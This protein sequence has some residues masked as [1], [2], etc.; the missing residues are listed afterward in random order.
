MRQFYLLNGNGAKFDLMTSA[1]FFHAPEGLGSAKTQ[2]FLRTG[3]FYKRTE[4]YESQ[5]SPSGEMIFRNYSDYHTFAMFIQ[6]EP[7]ILV[8]KPLDTEYRLNCTVSKFEKSE[9]SHENNRLIC[10]ITFTGTSKW[11]DLRSAI[12]SHP[13]GDDAKRYPYTYDYKYYDSLSGVIEG[14]N[15]SPNDV[16]CVLRI[17]GYCLNPTWVLSTNNVQISSGS[18]SVEL[19]DGEQLVVNS[20]DDNLE[21]AKYS[22]QNEYLANLYQDAAIDRENFLYIPSGNFK[23][24]IN[25]ESLSDITASLELLEEYDTV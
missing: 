5:K 21:I 3:D 18:V 7:L 16:P 25:D 2:S 1:G 8:Y 13:L 12:T 22:L 10:P 17:R 6:I 23:I 24:T 15:N 4:N 14:Y 19:I 20:R 9:I 11:Y